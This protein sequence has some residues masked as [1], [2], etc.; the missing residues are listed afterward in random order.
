MN[1]QD[2]D[3]Q[4]HEVLRAWKIADQL[5][6]RFGQEVWRR[7]ALEESVRVGFWLRTV[8]WF[9][10]AVRRPSL[11]VSYVTVLLLVG[12]VAGYWHARQDTNQTVERLGARYVQ[13]MDPYQMP[14]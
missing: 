6:P 1:N 3:A 13:M 2:S 12:L 11:A 7:I 5:P 14:R 4:L 8:R 10:D 9:D